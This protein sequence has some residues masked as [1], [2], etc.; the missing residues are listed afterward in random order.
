MLIRG[1]LI[2]DEVCLHYIVQFQ[3]IKVDMA[4]MRESGVILKESLEFCL[5]G[6]LPQMRGLT[7]L[8][9]DIRAE[10]HTHHHMI[11]KLHPIQRDYLNIHPKT[12]LRRD[13]A[14][15]RQA[16]NL[17]RDDEPVR[18]KRRCTNEGDEEGT[19]NHPSIRVTSLL[20][21]YMCFMRER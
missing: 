14:W 15:I 3:E 11:N 20:W 10:M 13:L 1:T 12:H 21:N 16:Q 18:A 6:Q 19:A 9:I 8:S 2:V 17:V 4:V 7:P 5:M